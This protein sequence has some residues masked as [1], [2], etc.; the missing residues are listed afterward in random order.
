MLHAC[1]SILPL[2]SVPS[3]SFSFLSFLL[4]HSDAWTSGEQERNARCPSPLVL[5]PSKPWQ[6]LLLCIRAP[7]ARSLLSLLCVCVSCVRV[8]CRGADLSRGRGKQEPKQQQQQARA[9]GQV[10]D[11]GSSRD[12]PIIVQNSTLS[13]L[14]FTHSLGPSP[15]LSRS[16]SLSLARSSCASSSVDFFLFPLCW[17]EK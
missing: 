16:L 13:C 7:D 8:W 9:G 11:A 6:S 12:A 2:F 14:L 15:S 3:V 10:R 4:M 1:R 17:R 5:P